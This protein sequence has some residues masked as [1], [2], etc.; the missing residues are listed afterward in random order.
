MPEE[1]GKW[2]WDQPKSWHAMNRTL[3]DIAVLLN[4]LNELPDSRLLSYFKATQDRVLDGRTRNTVPPCDSYAEFLDRLDIIAAAFQ[5]G[6]PPPEHDGPGPIAF[7]DWSCDFLAAV[8][9]P[10]TASSIR[11]T[12]QY[13]IHRS[14]GFL[15]SLCRPLGWLCNRFGLASANT[16]SLPTLPPDPGDS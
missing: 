2:L 8:A 11:L 12:R 3:H 4:Y 6:R 9:A 1:P 16:Q 10:A 14:R 15:A 7:V 5:T 13:A